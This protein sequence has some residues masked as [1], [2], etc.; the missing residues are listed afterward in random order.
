M[1]TNLV[2]RL[3]FVTKFCDLFVFFYN[4]FI[5]RLKDKEIYLIYIVCE[6]V[7]LGQL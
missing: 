3:I 2:R 1:A 5:P 6:N 4:F 7:Q